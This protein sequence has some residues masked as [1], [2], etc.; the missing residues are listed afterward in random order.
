MSKNDFLIQIQVAGLTSRLKRLNDSILYSTKEF[1]KEIGTDI[2]PNWYLIFILLQDHKE[3]SIMEIAEKVQ[4]SH[5]AVIKIIQKMKDKDYV[6]THTDPLDSRKQVV[7][8]S[9]KAYQC[10]P[11]FEKY[12]NACIATMQ[13]LVEANPH[14]VASLTSIEKMIQEKSYKQRTQ[15][16]FKKE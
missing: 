8:L 5:P 2:E 14:F 4:L 16:N 15:E 6:L 1:Y 3:L 13:E 10:I 7:R 9:D 11:E 12:W